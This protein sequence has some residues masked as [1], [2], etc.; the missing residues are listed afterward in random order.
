MCQDV[1]DCSNFS[2]R[3]AD[4]HKGKKISFLY[5][6]RFGPRGALFTA[7]ADLGTRNDQYSLLCLYHRIFSGASH[8]FKWVIIGGAIFST[9][10]GF[11]AVITI[12]F[13]CTPVQ[14]YWEPEITGSH[15]IRYDIALHIFS[16]TNVVT[17]AAILF[18]P[19]PLVWRMNTSFSR[20]TQISGVF[21]LGFI[22]TVVSIVRAYYTFRT[23]LALKSDA[24]WEGSY[25]FLWA[26]AETGIGILAACLPVLRPVLNKVLYGTVETTTT[27]ARSAGIS[28]PSHG[29]G[30]CAAHL[31]TIGGRVIPL[32]SEVAA[33]NG[34][35]GPRRASMVSF[36]VDEKRSSV[37]PS[38]ESV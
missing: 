36:L 25:L 7:N 16:I 20:K 21:L 4:C 10:H 11:S 9:C 3:T 30:S 2:L 38:H 6:A 31:V 23:S 17:D 5:H 24:T 35:A 13:S 34:G 22:V 28:V 1:V 37:G 8:R 14:S 12:V 18:L 27:R 19:M 32:R 15:C 26:T 33:P 29:D